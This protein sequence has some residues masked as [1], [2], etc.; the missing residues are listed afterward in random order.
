MDDCRDI[1]AIE[2][3]VPRSSGIP[4]VRSKTTIWSLMLNTLRRGCTREPRYRSV[5]SNTMRKTAGHM[6]PTY[7]LSSY[8]FPWQ[9][10]GLMYDGVP[11]SVMAPGDCVLITYRHSLISNW[12]DKDENLSIARTLDMPKS[13]SFTVPSP[14]RN[15]LAVFRSRCKILSSC[16]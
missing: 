4:E 14:I 12:A 3:L 15:T 16:M 6:L 9:S 11:H 7:T 2:C 1:G 13:P 8:A 10:S 5:P